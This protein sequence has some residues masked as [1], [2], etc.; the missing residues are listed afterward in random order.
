MNRL[1]VC[2]GA[3]I[4]L[5]LAMITVAARSG[6]AVRSGDEA[7]LRRIATGENY[8]G[9]RRAG[10]KPRV[11]GRLDARRLQ[12]RF[13]ALGYDLEKVRARTRPVPQIFLA[14]LPEDLGR[15]RLVSQ[16]KRLF[17]GAVLPLVLRA[18]AEVGRE[19]RFLLELRTRL[20]AGDEL[21][22]AERRR[23][24][25]L[26]LG[27]EVESGDLDA[28]LRRV[29]V[30][31]PSLALAQAVEESGWGTSRFAR[32][33]NAVFG[34]RTWRTGGGMV[35]L[36]RE[37]GK[38]HEVAAFGA[39]YASVHAYLRNLNSH[40]AYRDFR[41]LRARARARGGTATA[42]ALIRTMT[43]YSERG[44]AYIRAILA[45]IRVNRLGAYDKARLAPDTSV[46][47][48]L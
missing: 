10:T 32:R 45:I 16:R 25:D 33:G 17:I 18:N 7:E 39:L 41:R 22:V 48:M 30:V 34:Q 36:R 13:R 15:L 29:D 28:L 40:P 46:G 20:H 9:K 24:E 35:P 11:V 21:A 23:L 43:R 3:V 5:G 38:R 37:N 31:P 44:P 14:A 2:A 42:A 26:A 4:A 1:S 8:A 19:R 27:Y 12:A 47:I 6:E